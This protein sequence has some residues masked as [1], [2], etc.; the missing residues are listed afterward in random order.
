MKKT[1]IA[2]NIIKGVLIKSCIYFT[3]MTLIL[4]AGALLFAQDI[5]SPN[6][7]FMFA[8]AALGAGVAVQVFKIT[9]IPAVSR[10]IAFFILLYIDFFLVIVTL[11]HYTATPNTT[12]FL[13]VFFIIIYLVILG[14]VMGIKSAINA[15]ANKKLKYE[16]Q[17]E[18]IKID[19]E[20]N[21]DD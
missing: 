17:F 12:F 3:A 11:R 14:I 19:S 9:R 15:S 6:T 5:F 1:K 7:C 13:S 18:N 16:K 10:H 2:I 21:E 20:E 8:M 4:T